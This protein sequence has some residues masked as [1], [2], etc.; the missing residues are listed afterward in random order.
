MEFLVSFLDI[1]NT[2]IRFYG[3]RMSY[4]EFFG[5]LLGL[6]SVWLATREN[7][8]TWTTGIFNVIAYFIIYYQI[9]L[10]SD[11]FLQ[12][13]FLATSIIGLLQWQKRK[14]AGNVKI[15]GFLDKKYLPGMIV[16]ILAFALLL[17]FYMSGI[18]NHF[19][20]FFSV[21]ASFP[22]ADA[23]IAVLSIYA[24]FLMAFKKTECWILWILVD[25][26]SVVLYFQKGVLFI[27]IEYMIFLL[28]A[29][30]GLYQWLKPKGDEKR[31]SIG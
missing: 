2:F 14:G 18:H 22:Y 29:C 15:T 30:M 27:S 28:M 13:F 16:S 12:L 8:H 21:P 25:M 10:Y 19:P 23:F 11:M 17:G 26:V 9:S 3:Y 7:I 1:G 6:V 5:T 31:L 24:T 4:I 20:D